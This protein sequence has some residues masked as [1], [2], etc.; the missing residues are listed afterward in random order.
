MGQPGHEWAEHGRSLARWDAAYNEILNLTPAG[1]RQK[2]LRD[3]MLSSIHT[4][5]ET[6]VKREH[7]ARNS[8]SGMFWFAAVTGVVFTGLAFYP[9]TP[10]R[11]NLRLLGLL[12]AFT[13]I[14]LFFIFAFSNP[15]KDPGSL[16]PDG[17]HHLLRQLDR[18]GQ[19]A[20]KQET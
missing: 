13:G 6:R 15:F 10:R 8:L 16:R 20:T 11:G 2:S 12:G 14:I 9:Y 17:F 19:A 4:I 7:H 3:H 1:D 5:A 18:A